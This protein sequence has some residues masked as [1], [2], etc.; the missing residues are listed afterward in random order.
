MLSFFF[1]VLLRP[2]LL[3]GGATVVGLAAPFFLAFVATA[4]ALLTAFF[5]SAARFSAALLAAGG[6]LGLCTR[7][8]DGVRDALHAFVHAGVVLL[9][10]GIGFSVMLRGFLPRR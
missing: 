6:A 9:I 2:T 3:L 10:I 5:W 8:F 4:L 7:S 1:R